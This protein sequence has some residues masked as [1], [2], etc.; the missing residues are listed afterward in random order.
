MG[1]SLPLGLSIP[2]W[3]GRWGGRARGESGRGMRCRGLAVAIGG[4]M[5]RKMPCRG[6]GLALRLGRRLGWW[7]SWRWVGG[8]GTMRGGSVRIGFDSKAMRVKG[9][10]VVL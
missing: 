7:V 6:C 10:G 3:G 8:H 4:G 9:Y 1:L 2:V 5:G